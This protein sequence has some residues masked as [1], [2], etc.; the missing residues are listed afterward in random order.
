[1]RVCLLSLVSL[2]KSGFGFSSCDDG[3]NIMYGGNA[4]GHA[5]LK[6]D[7]LVLDL[8]DHYNNSYSGFVSHFNFDYETIKWHARLGYIG[9][10]RISRLAKEGL[11]D[12]LTKVELPRC[13]LCLTGKATAK[14]FDRA[15]R[16]SSPLKLIHS[17]ICVSMNV[18]ARHGAFY[19]FHFR[20]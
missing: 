3:L 9:Q 13:E 7:F 14:S 17:N 4:F 2:I 5:A 19:F 11:L 8:D 18:K 12:Q 16:P 6:N 15:S 1:M 10:D 20:R